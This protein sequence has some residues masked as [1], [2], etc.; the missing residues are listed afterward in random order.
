MLRNLPRV[1]YLAATEP[2]NK[3][4]LKQA[5]IANNFGRISERYYYD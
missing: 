3:R 2:I 1:R 4:V 5:A